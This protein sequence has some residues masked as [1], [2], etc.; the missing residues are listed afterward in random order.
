M[1]PD[2]SEAQIARL[3]TATVPD[4]LFSFNYPQEVFITSWASWDFGGQVS[5]WD[6]PGTEPSLDKNGKERVVVRKPFSKEDRSVLVYPRPMGKLGDG[7]TEAPYEIL[8][9]LRGD[10][11]ERLLA[12]EG[13]LV[14]RAE[15]VAK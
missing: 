2:A 12:E 10:D 13:G 4:D 5:N 3:A 1:D 7:G 14:S 8:L 9:Q 11:M 6:I 15:R